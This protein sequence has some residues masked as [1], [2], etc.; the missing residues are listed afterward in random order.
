MNIN[1][2]LKSIN[3][4]KI[5]LAKELGLSRP[6]L[7]QYIYLFEQGRKIEN[8]RYNIIF[9]RLFSNEE[10]SKEEFEYQLNFVKRLLERDKKY[11]IVDLDTE[12]ADLISRIHNNMI[13]DMEAGN[14]DRKVYD[15][16]LILLSNYRDNILMKEL[17]SYFS[18]LNS[19]S[20]LSNISNLTK[21]YYSYYYSFFKNI[22][23]NHPVYNEEEYTLFINRKQELAEKKRK[24][25]MEKKR[26]VN[27]TIKNILNE[28]EIDCQKAG[29]DASEDEIMSEVIRR[30]KRKKN[31]EKS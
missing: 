10:I 28:I 13:K 26:N 6:T 3:K 8:E 31:V 7:D 29:V 23:H 30:L 20:D 19:D 25:K 1:F 12:S 24:R 2:F 21:A 11:G 9:K 27:N 22:V 16:I 14:W 17:A 5:E 15:A 4:T 18:D